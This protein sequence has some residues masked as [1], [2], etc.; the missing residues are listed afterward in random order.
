MSKSQ[1]CSTSFSESFDIEFQETLF[2]GK[3]ADPRS[4]AIDGLTRSPHNAFFVY[5]AKI[6]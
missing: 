5:S 1:P 2:N 3:G 6:A 4:S